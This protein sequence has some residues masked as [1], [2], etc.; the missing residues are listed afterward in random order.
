MVEPGA[1]T[2]E[3]YIEAA[4]EERRPTWDQ[5]AQ[6][7]HEL[8]FERGEYAGTAVPLPGYHLTLAVGHPWKAKIEE[9]QAVFDESQSLEE[10]DL[11]PF[12][13]QYRELG[14]D[15]ECVER[16]RWY[17]RTLD[18]HVVLAQ[19]GSRVEA[20]QAHTEYSRRLTFDLKTFGAAVVW[21]VAAEFRAMVKLERL[22][23]GH[24]ARQYLM[25]GGFLETSERSHVTYY[26]RKL[27]PTLALRPGNGGGM[28]VL[29]A[30]C[31]HPIGFYNGTRAG[32]MVPTDDVIAHVLLCRGDEHRFWRQANQ[33]APWEAEAGL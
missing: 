33:H 4:V 18:A 9:I 26:F 30:L 24:K 3:A 5:V 19:V 12:A 2:T 13:K 16:N 8:G 22:I 23:G 31:L 25:T 29:A 1:V 11:L 17:S 15:V 20:F 10:S 28:K 14:S 21:D 32:V 6:K 27:R 7:L